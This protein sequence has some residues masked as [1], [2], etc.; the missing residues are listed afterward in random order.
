MKARGLAS[1]D[2]ADC[3]ALTFAVKVAPP[4]KVQPP[5]KPVSAWS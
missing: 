5:P 2:M 4:V 3:L 1:P